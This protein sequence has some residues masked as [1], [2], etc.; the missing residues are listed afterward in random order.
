MRLRATVVAQSSAL[1]QVL[2]EAVDANGERARMSM[3]PVT[4]T[5]AE[6]AR[7]LGMENALNFDMSAP[8]SPVKMLGQG[9][10]V[11]YIALPATAATATIVTFTADG[12]EPAELTLN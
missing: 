4:C 5:V 10:L 7:L 1:A 11:A 3:A 8:Q 6:G 9:R 2:V 12:M